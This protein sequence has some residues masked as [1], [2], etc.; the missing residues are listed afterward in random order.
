L[1]IDE[2]RLLIFELTNW[3]LFLSTIQNPKST[4]VNLPLFP[5]PFKI[6][7]PSSKIPHLLSLSL[8]SFTDR[9]SL[10]TSQYTYQIGILR[11]RAF[12]AFHDRTAI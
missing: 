11:I 7:I 9:C 6:Q 1:T 10:G 2:L 5:S 4:I 12:F 3:H 8:P